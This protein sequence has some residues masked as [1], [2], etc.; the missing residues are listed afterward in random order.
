[1][2]IIYVSLQVMSQENHPKYF[3]G[4]FLQ[5]KFLIAFKVYV[6]SYIYYFYIL[7]LNI[8]SVFFLWWLF[9]NINTERFILAAIFF[10]KICI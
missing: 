3:I 9:V 5:E 7:E 1:M 4:I 6:A 8:T 2:K 10:I